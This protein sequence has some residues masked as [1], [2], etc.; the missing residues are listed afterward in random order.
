MPLEY[1]RFSIVTPVK[2]DVNI[3]SLCA[4]L[5]QTKGFDK[6]EMLIVRNGTPSSSVREITG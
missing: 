6:A 2:D 4:S 3:E 1:P 5:P